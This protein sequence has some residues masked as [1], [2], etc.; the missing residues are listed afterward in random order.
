MKANQPNTSYVISSGNE[1][2]EAISRSALSPTGEEA[3]SISETQ[4]VVRGP[5]LP[6]HSTLTLTPVVSLAPIPSYR[7]FA[8][9]MNIFTLP[10]N[11]F[12]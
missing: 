6:G 1:F 9:K 12:Y 11:L 5:S 3:Q 10:Q 8:E 2:Q 4:I 7:I